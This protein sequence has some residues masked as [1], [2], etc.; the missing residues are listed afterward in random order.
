[1]VLLNVMRDGDFGG[2]SDIGVK[3]MWHE[4]KPKLK[5]WHVMILGALTPNI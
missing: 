4:L 3:M 2:V 1:M 5:I